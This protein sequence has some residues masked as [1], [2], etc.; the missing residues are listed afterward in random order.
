MLEAR[1]AIDALLQ[2]LCRGDAPVVSA[3]GLLFALTAALQELALGSGWSI[4]YLAYAAE[5]YRLQALC[6]SDRGAP[7]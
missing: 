3:L 4:A 7:R 5:A 2:P 1:A 6:Q